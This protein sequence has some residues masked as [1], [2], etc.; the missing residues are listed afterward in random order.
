MR[1][2][3]AAGPRAA[4][5][6]TLLDH[7]PKNVLF[8]LDARLLDY[9]RPLRKVGLDHCGELSGRVANHFETQRDNFG[10]N[11]GQRERVDGFEMEPANNLRRRPRR[12]QLEE[13]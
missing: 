10:A 3:D 4:C 8:R 1:R 12:R 9:F 5:H 11:V 13:L 2:R 6:D 7:A